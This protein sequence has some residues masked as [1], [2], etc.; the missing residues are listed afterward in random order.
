[1][2]GSGIA[3]SYNSG[4]GIMTLTGIDSFANYEAA[5]ALVAYSIDGDNP[6]NY[7]ASASRTLSYAVFDGL[8][9]SDENDT[10]ITVAGTNDAPVN[11]TGG[12]VAAN[13]DDS[14]VAVT[15]LSV[16]D[17]DDDCAHRHP[18]GR[19]RHAH[20]R[21]RRGRWRRRRAGHRQRHRHA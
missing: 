17:T 13:E 3:Y 1:M 6:D 9:L 11:T 7:G 18:R 4:T 14:S 19:P 15:G 16:S 12:A 2:L 8:L 21:H 5:L 20:D 10:V